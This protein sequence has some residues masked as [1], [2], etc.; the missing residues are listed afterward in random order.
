[1]F[2]T[3]ILFILGTVAWMIIDFVIGYSFIS[4]LEF[5]SNKVKLTRKKK[6]IFASIWVVVGLILELI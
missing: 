1:M 5:L 4:V 6:I 2:T 3:Y